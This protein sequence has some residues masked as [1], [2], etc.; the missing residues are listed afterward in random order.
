MSKI[1]KKTMFKYEGNMY[2]DSFPFY[3]IL[4]SLYSLGNCQKVKWHAFIFKC[5][6]FLYIIVYKL[7]DGGTMKLMIISIYDFTEC[8]EIVILYCY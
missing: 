8:S 4:N 1:Q 2:F 3:I 5:I 6:L 7:Y